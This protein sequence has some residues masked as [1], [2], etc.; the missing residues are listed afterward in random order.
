MV[1]KNVGSALRYCL[2]QQAGRKLG[3]F[4]E[5]IKPLVDFKYEVGVLLLPIY[6]DPSLLKVIE[7]RLNSMFE[8]ATQDEIDKLRTNE[9]SSDKK[10]SEDLQLED[11]DVK[12]K[13][14]IF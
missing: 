7:T 9:G 4:W 8:L 11:L 3:E 2:P 5:L 1:V 10:S 13:M 6:L 12:F 14:S